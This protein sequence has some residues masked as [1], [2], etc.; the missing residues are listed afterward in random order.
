MDKYIFESSSSDKYFYI[1][2]KK[3]LF[4][5]FNRKKLIWISN[6]Q[7]SKKLMALIK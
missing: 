5:I 3:K 2:N 7:N 6:L 4:D 1:E